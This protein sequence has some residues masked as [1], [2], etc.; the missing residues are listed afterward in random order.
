[1]ASIT[2][3]KTSSGMRYKAEILI[4]EKGEIIHRESKTFSKKSI[5]SDWATERELELKSHGGL[6]KL[7]YSKV[8]VGNIVQRYIDNFRPEG[9]WGRSKEF[10]VKKLLTY[11]LAKKS[12]IDLSTKDLIAHAKWRKEGN[13]GPATIANDY[14]WLLGAFKTIKASAGIPLDLSVFDDARVILRQHGMIAKPNERERR[15]TN[16]ELWK[17]SRYFWRKQYR[18]SRSVIP[19]FTIMWFQIYSAKRI[20]E[21][22]RIEWADNNNDKHTGM[23]RDAKHPR[24]KV[25]NHK[26][27]KYSDR[28]WKIIE[29]WPNID[30]RIFP[31]DPKSASNAFTKACKKLGIK[32][33]RLHDLRHEGTS[34][35]F[36]EGY[37]IE[38]VAL[39]TLHDD[40]KTLKRYTH[41]RPED[42]D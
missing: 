35:L 22:C 14:V 9:G 2:K 31:Y 1:M 26:R 33:L 17:L 38:Q 3:R 36:E 7:K 15:P 13:T 23:V 34:R 42:V 4:K 27:F 16:K 37:S 30:D 10:D 29:R 24:K 28:A 41:L 39:H 11:P 20:S 5:A 21:T 32:D 25:G 19:M 18:D 40:W 12:A 8:T 6:E